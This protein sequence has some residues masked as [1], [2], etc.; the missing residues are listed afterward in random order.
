[1][2]AR[3]RLAGVR[4]S[5]RLVLR[6]M[7]EHGLLAPG[8][9]PQ[10]AEP[11]RHEGTILT[12]QPNQMWGIDATAGFTAQDG[13]VAIFT[14]VDHYSAYCLGIHA[15]KRGTRFEA[16]EP[17]RQAVQEQ[18]GGFS[19]AV[20]AGVTSGHDQGSQFM[21][22]DFPAELRFL[23]IESSPAF[24]RE[25]GSNGYIELFFRTFKEQPLWGRHFEAT[26]ELTEALLKS[27]QR[28]NRQWLIDLPQFHSPGRLIR[29]CLLSSLP[30]DDHSKHSPGNRSA[31]H[32][33]DPSM[34]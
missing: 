29:P 21:S 18:F 1:V 20:A 8:R 3:L 10:P 34:R 25:L 33:T 16:L 19:A 2:R 11:K 27:R 9:P 31:Q 14:M 4:N 26:E 23:G 30:R 5:K 24:L 7:R 15:A 22:A 12:E 17:V 13:Q 28:Y 32:S 6:L